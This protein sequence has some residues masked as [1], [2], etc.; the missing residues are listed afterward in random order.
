MSKRKVQFTT[1]NIYH[2]YNRGVH[3]NDIYLSDADYLRWEKLLTWS[4]NYNYS[5]SLYLQRLFKI[6]GPAGETEAF[7]KSFAEN[8]KYS[9]PLVKI[10]VYVEM[11]NHYH[12]VLEQTED[13][14]ISR[15]MQKLSTAYTMYFNEKYN[16]SG[17]LFQSKF[18]AVEV[19]TDEQFVQLL[20]YVLN[21]PFNAKLVGKNKFEYKWSSLTEH[22]GDKGGE[23]VEMRR[24]PDF[25][26]NKQK[27]SKFLKNEI[28]ESGDDVLAGLRIETD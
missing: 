13:D 6:Q 10:L 16:I 20:R 9:C 21:N 22:V 14:G 23:I 19:M 18:Q 24:L 15:F 8:Y 12:L 3:K 27:L 26:S 2:I 25:F 28:M 17:S 5:Y 11:P 7:I 1:N 4:A